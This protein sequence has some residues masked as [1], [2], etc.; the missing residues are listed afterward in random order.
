MK[1]IPVLLNEVIEYLNIKSDGVYIDATCGFGGHAEKILERID[2]GGELIGIELDPEVANETKDKFIRFKNQFRVICDNF[3]NIEKITRRFGCKCVDGILFDLG[4]NLYQIKESSK[5]FSFLRSAPLDMR[6][7]PKFS[8]LPAYKIVNTW[9]HESLEKL[10]RESDEWRARPIVKAIIERRRQK[11]ILTTDDL[12]DVILRAVHGKRGRIHPATKVFQALRI[13]ANFELENIKEAIPEAMKMLCPQGRIIV[14]SFHSGE[15]RIIKQAFRQA[16]ER[17][18]VKILT[19]K[20]IVPEY[21]EKRAN[22][23]SRSAK[24]RVIEKL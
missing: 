21:Q 7:N 18:I 19:K 14:I 24:M 15:D 1:H 17:G 3:A 16:E 4:T 22:P 13:A 8:D 2:K 12:A 9:S 20:P 11:K 10:F 5:G 23:Q 6:F